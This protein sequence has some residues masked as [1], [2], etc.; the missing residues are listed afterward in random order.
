MP[1]LV[2]DWCS[3]G[4]EHSCDAKLVLIGEAPGRREDELKQPFVGESGRALERWWEPHG[5]RRSDFYITNVYPYRPP[6]NKIEAIPKDQLAFWTQ[7]LHE[8]LARLADPFVIVPTGNVALRALFG[9]YRS[10]SDWRGSIIGYQD[11]NGRTIKVIPT[12]HPA[13]T[14]R[15]PI[16]TKFCI[17]DWAKIAHDRTFRELAIPERTIV[18]EPS[19]SEFGSFVLG[20]EASSPTIIDGIPVPPVMSVDIETDRRTKELLC[21]GFS[22]RPNEAL[23][24]PLSPRA[25]GSRTLERMRHY[26]TVLC[27]SEANKVLQNGQFDWFHLERNGIPLRNY[28]YDLIEMMHCLD[29]ND[30]GDVGAGADSPSGD[31]IKISMKSLA[32]LAS[33]YTR[34]P[35]WKHQGRQDG[36]FD[37]VGLMRYNGIDCCVTR[38]VFDHLYVELVREG[39]I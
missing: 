37:W 38:E 11:L 29:P 9:D 25:V 13:A 26:A 14:F 7:R 5:L 10:I 35:F 27:A 31:G 22:H 16:L 33:L 39:R 34:Q 28:E 32:V 12:F 18:V 1:N 2:P 3:H 4:I 36:Q 24:L 30:G 6:S 15:Q 8:R 17:A 21:V 19:E 23:V 20:L